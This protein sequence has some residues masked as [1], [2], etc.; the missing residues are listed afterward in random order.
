MTLESITRKFQKVWRKVC[1]KKYTVAWIAFM[2]TLIWLT[3]L[4]GQIRG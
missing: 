4:Y 2:T 1:M 3:L